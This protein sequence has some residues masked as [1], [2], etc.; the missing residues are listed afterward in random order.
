MFYFYNGFVY[1]YIFPGTHEAEAIIRDKESAFPNS[2]L[3][4]FFRGRIH[5]LRVNVSL[6]FFLLFISLIYF[7]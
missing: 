2:S 3:F 7:K 5:R 1:L 6:N 4:L